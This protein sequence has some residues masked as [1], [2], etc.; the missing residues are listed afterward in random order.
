MSPAKPRIVLVAALAQNGVI[1]AENRMPWHLPEDLRHFK[2]LTLGK[3]VLM[4][5][6]TW[7]SLGRPLPGRN[8]IVITRDPQ[9]RPEGAQVAHSVA[10]ALALAGAVTEICVIGGAEIYA[11][12]LP[13]ADCLELTE[14]A[15]EF[16]GDTRFPA[17]EPRDWREVR[18]EAHQS[19]SGLAYAFVTYQRATQST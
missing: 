9:Y 5:R 2:A 16:A 13:L 19:E 4:G 8:N 6:K 3:P 17:W 7:E 10:E 1:G 12:T 14:I 11:L 15:Q 18:R